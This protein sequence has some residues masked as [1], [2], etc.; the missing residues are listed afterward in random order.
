MRILSNM[1]RLCL[2][3]LER[4]KTKQRALETLFSNISQDSSLSS[5]FDSQ[6]RA[7]WLYTGREGRFYPTD[8]VNAISSAETMDAYADIIRNMAKFV[9]ELLWL[10][11]DTEIYLREVYHLPAVQFANVDYCETTSA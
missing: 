7:A 8:A 2:S 9:C 1:K 10:L 11:E 6:F 3:S 4:L 5:I